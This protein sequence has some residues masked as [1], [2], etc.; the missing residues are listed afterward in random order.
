MEVTLKRKEIPQAKKYEVDECGYVYRNN[1]KLTQSYRSGK[2][3]VQLRGNDGRNY[4]VDTIKLTNHIFGDELQMSMDDI[5]HSLKARTI[6]EFPRY[7]ITSYGA[8]YCVDPP[9]RGPKAG[10]RYLLRD[11]IHNGKRYVTL[12]HVDGRRRCRQVDKLVE[13]TWGY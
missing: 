1:K 4:T 2:W 8:V 3:Y 7:A 9:R 6:E 5:L 11:N 12:Y 10:Q 13:V